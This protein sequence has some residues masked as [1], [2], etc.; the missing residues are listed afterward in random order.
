MRYSYPPYA[1][2]LVS[3]P[4][5]LIS[6]AAARD[7]GL[8]S[9]EGAYQ[10][11]NLMYHVILI[12]SRYTCSTIWESPQISLT[13]YQQLSE[14]SPAISE[15]VVDG[16]YHYPSKVFARSCCCPVSFSFSLR[17]FKI[18]QGRILS[19]S[20]KQAVCVTRFDQSECVICRVI[21]ALGKSRFQSCIRRNFRFICNF[22]TI[23]PWKVV[24][25]LYLDSSH[26]T[27]KY[28]AFLSV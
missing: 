12:T 17:L 9:W 8:S 20:F 28:N 11:L 16:K 26:V 22:D 1:P 3:R 27:F 5:V 25:T 21:F 14:I 6:Y 7:Y 18:A 19:P 4:K 24:G 10:S 15:I 13:L 23:P 2:L